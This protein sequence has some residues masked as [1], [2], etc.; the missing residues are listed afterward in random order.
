MMFTSEVPPLP[1]CCSIQA[2]A[3]LPVRV[4]MSLGEGPKL[5]WARKRLASLRL[6][7]VQSG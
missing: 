5:A 6:P 2:L 1:N 3:V 4:V 7:S